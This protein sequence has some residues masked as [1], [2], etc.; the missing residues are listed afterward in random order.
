MI[1]AGKL[2]RFL[3]EISF[4]HYLGTDDRVVGVARMLIPPCPDKGIA[5]IYPE[6]N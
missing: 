4:Y 5:A 1:V 6:L 3:P 2:A